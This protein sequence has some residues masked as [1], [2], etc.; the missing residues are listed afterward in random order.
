MINQKWYKDIW[1][2]DIKNQSWVEDTKNQI[3]FIIKIMKLRGNERILDLT[4][5]FGRHSLLLSSLGYNVVGVDITKDYIADA[6][7]EAKKKNLNIEFVHADIRELTYKDEFDVVINM[8]D[9][10]IGYLENEEENL[11]IFDIIVKSLKKNGKHFMDICNAEHAEL[12]FPKKDWEIGTNSIS[13]PSFIWEKEIRRMLYNQIEIAIGKVVEKPKN[14]EPISTTRLYSK[15]ELRK[16]L[17]IRGMKIVNTYCN[18]YGKEDTN[19][20]LQ[21]MIYSKKIK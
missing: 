3:D 11:K 5:G 4:C 10:A 16:I 21:L 19:K 15:K 12:Y 14:L 6:K 9:G 2:L 17:R 18:Y 20:E 7:K 1:N 13:L 8:A